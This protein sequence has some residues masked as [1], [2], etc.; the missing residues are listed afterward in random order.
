MTRKLF[1]VQKPTGSKKGVFDG[2]KKE[3]Q[4][5]WFRTS[6]ANTH[7]QKNKPSLHLEKVQKVLM[8]QTVTAELATYVRQIR[9]KDSTIHNV[10][11]QVRKKPEK[12]PATTKEQY[13]TETWTARP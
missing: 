11:S 1:T 6:D 7:E 8:G 5:R 9:D 13:V 2:Q 12:P 4:Q 10:S 3:Q